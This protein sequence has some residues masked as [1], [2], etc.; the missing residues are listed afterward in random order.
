MDMQSGLAAIVEK[1]KADYVAWWGKRASEPHIQQ[2]IAD[3][4]A[5]IRIEEGSKYFKIIKQ[6]SVHSFV[7]KKD[8]KKFRAG[9]ILKPASWKAPAMNF[10]RGNV[11]EGKLDCIRWTGAL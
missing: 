4:N 1:S 5:S 11:L 2:M 8:G 9:D 7:V 10:A 6:N 3:F